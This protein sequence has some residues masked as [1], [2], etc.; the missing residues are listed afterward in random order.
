MIVSNKMNM[1]LNYACIIILIVACYKTCLR[2]HFR[3]FCFC[4]VKGEATQQTTVRV[5]ALFILPYYLK[6]THFHDHTYIMYI[7][8]PTRP[9]GTQ[10]Y[11]STF[12]CCMLSVRGQRLHC[13][14]TN[15][16]VSEACKS[17][18]VNKGKI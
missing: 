10:I 17:Y 9:L 15:N 7:L 13:R 14:F 3:P 12:R 5:R 2:L 1:H 18:E 4:H 16:F 6:K 8:R 11:N